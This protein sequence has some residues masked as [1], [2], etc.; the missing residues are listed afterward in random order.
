MSG[1][2]DGVT[3]RTITSIDELAECKR[4]ASERRETPLF[5]DTESAGLSPYMDECRLIQIGDLRTGWAA[6]AK[7]WGGGILEILRDYQGELGAHNSPYDYRVIDHQLGL[8]L[9]WAKIHDTLMSCH[10]HDSIMPHGL[11][12]AGTRMV[13]P[14]AM[15]GEKILQ[16]AMADNHWTWATVPLDYPGYTAYAALDPVLSAHLWVKTGPAAMTTFREAYDLERATGRI[17]AQM[18]DAGM[19][20]DVP[21]IEKQIEHL[22]AW[23]RGARAWLYEQHKMT[24]VNSPKQIARVLESVGIPISMWTEGGEAATDK[25][26]MRVYATMYP[27]HRHLIET[28]AYTK[29]A[30]AIVNTHLRKF[31]A[32]RDS[33]DV[34]H[35]SINTCQA[36]TSRQSVTDPP[37]QTFD[38][39][40][41]MI[42]GAF[43]P[44]PGNAFVAVDADQIEARVTA[45][46]SDDR[47]MIEAFHQ[48]DETGVDFF[49]LLAGRIYREDPEKISKKDIRRQLTKNSTYAR[50][51]G[52]GLDKM[53]LT[54]GVPVEQ[55][56]PAYNA[57]GQL[58]P[59][60]DRLMEQI[61]RKC[62]AE[63]RAGGRGFV[64]SP[65]GRVLYVDKKREYAGLNYKIQCHAA[66][67]LKKG[68][69][70]LDAAGLTPYLRLTIHDEVLGEFPKDVAKDA[71]AT[72]TRILTDR[73]TY[74]VP[75]TWD[76]KIL[77]ERWVKS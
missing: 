11:K 49:R 15:E 2:L 66:E 27:Q 63:A 59:G 60:P 17:A 69:V 9:N 26:T 48:A 55:A 75:I 71:L 42:R 21:Y 65:L 5:F 61:I 34:I 68:V 56:A 35:A 16:K 3:L 31:L 41:P 28:I 12:P 51:Y 58:Y 18:M 52:S 22:E 20:L 37:M 33:N 62:K 73:T 57:F 67:I 36:R 23:E 70:Q 4:W 24:S 44:W 30:H 53:A 25:D 47:G 54:A 43:R 40:V 1:V 45:D 8:K 32:L 76:G 29:K 46:F 6:P 10:L 13:D 50:I 74:K 77:E 72:M 38:R 39:D 19:L 64:T 14:R 7:L